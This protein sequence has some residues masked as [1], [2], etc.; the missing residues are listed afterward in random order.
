[1]AKKMTKVYIG[2]INPTDDKHER[3]IEQTLSAAGL[4]WSK[5]TIMKGPM[6]LISQEFLDSIKKA[7]GIKADPDA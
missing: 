5:M 2:F 3:E 4:I 7:A 6:T 1:M